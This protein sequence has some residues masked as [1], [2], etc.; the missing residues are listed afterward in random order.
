MDWDRCIFCD[1][2]DA[3]ASRIKRKP[4]KSSAGAASETAEATEELHAD[5]AASA[6]PEEPSE[7]GNPATVGA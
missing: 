1:M 4:N 5:A 3:V 7:I 2:Y 6:V